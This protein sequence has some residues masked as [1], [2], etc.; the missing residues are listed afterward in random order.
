MRRGVSR[1]LLGR[2]LPLQVNRLERGR[3][4]CY[5]AWWGQLLS[6]QAFPPRDSGGQPLL[7][8]E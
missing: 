5:V 2:A 7:L 1:R 6:S 3:R 8:L 4:A